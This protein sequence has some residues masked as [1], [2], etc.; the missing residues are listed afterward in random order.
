E[1]LQDVY[2]VTGWFRNEGRLPTALERAKEIHLVREDYAEIR[3]PEGMT[4]VDEKGNRRVP[5]FVGGRGR[6]RGFRPQAQTDGTVNRVNMGWLEGSMM[7]DYVPMRK[8]TWYAKVEG[9]GKRT[10]TVGIGSTRGGVH[11]V[12]IELPR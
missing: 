11:S 9:A 1:G 12:K 8:V 10:I 7:K 5:S 4:L 2:R 3:L 6:G